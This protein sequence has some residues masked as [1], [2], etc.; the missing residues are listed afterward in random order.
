L[1][2]HIAGN[3]K[4]RFDNIMFDTHIFARLAAW[5][6]Q[7]LATGLATLID[8][9]GSSPRPRGA[10]IAATADGQHV[11][12]ISSGCAEEAIIAELVAAI[13]AETNH[14]TRYG[15]DSPYIDVVLPCG[16]GLDILFTGTDC[17]PLT[18]QV[19]ALHEARQTAY[20]TPQGD[21]SLSVSDAA[22]A[23]AIA[24]PPDYRLHI[25]GAGPQM[26]VFAQL[27]RAMNYTLIAHS[28]DE[29]SLHALA[30]MGV[31]AQ[32][33]THQTQFDSAAF[34]AFSAVITLFHEHEMET[35]ILQAALNSEAHYIGALGSRKTHE[36]RR[37][38]LNAAQTER[39]FE[40]IIGPVGLD[41]GATDPAEIALSILAQIVEKRRL[42]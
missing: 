36:Q 12:V 37:L 14:V 34:D 30:A 15:K 21:N 40:V 6:A 31:E 28:N 8:I 26:T 17:A 4:T 9:D 3:Q 19:T 18:Q 42:K 20:V 35:P 1:S 5:Q 29:A 24:Y 2:I 39:P 13:A 16:S 11:G 41:I 7:G 33:M 27:A 25:F 32:A 10:Q 38:L 23:A 22:S